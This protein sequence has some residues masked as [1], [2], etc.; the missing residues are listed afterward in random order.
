MAKK[1]CLIWFMDNEARV[2]HFGTTILEVNIKT[3][4]ILYIGGYSQTDSKYMNELLYKW[5]FFKV[6]KNEGLF[7][8]HRRGGTKKRDDPCIEL[9]KRT[10]GKD[11]QITIKEGKRMC[12][13]LPIP[14]ITFFEYMK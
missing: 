5:K 2:T 9:W 3:K 1:D 14:F 8:I 4:E 7:T 13:L 11:E 6:G 12:I 10:N